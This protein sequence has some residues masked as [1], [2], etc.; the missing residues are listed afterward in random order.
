[1]LILHFMAGRFAL[2]CVPR[3]LMQ[4][5][6]RDKFFS[7]RLL[8]FAILFSLAGCTAYVPFGNYKMKD[9]PKTELA[10]N[11]YNKFQF[12][13]DYQNPYI[14]AHT[15]P[16]QYYFRTDGTWEIKGRDLILNSTN[17]SLKYPLS[18][19]TITEGEERD[20]SYFAFYDIY[21]E[22]IPILQVKHADGYLEEMNDSLQYSTAGNSKDT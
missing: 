6:W 22:R 12:I 20:S 10:L 18:H 7:M 21:N 19:I 5:P 11:P 2:Y 1:M 9:A 13:L 17:D 4:M 8:L 15:H 16:E 14:N 3:V